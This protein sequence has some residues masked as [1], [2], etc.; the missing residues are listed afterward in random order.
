[1]L[2]GREFTVGTIGSAKPCSLILPRRRYE[3][4]I[5]IGQTDEGAAAV[6]LSGQFRFKYFQ[7]SGNSRW[8]GLVI[9]C[10]QVDVDE[11]SLFDPDF[12]GCSPGAVV[13]TGTLLTV[14]ATFDGF[15]GRSG[16]VTLQSDLMPAEEGSA[17][18]SRWRVVIGEGQDKRV[19]YSVDLAK[20]EHAD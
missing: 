15:I 6:F 7:S 20:A 19:L 9:P 2:S 1:M 5:L 16:P 8:G 17:G 11:T 12:D 13:R 3:E 10:V 4:V 18:F 14:R